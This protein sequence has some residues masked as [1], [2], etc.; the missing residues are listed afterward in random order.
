MLQVATRCLYNQKSKRKQESS[1]ILRKLWDIDNLM[2]SR[3]IYCHKEKLF[4]VHLF[5]DTLIIYR[6]QKQS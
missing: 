1:V 6:S 2:N 5:I 4:V 3:L